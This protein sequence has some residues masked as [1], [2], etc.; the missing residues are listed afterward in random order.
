VAHTADVA[1]A[2]HAASGRVLRLVLCPVRCC[3]SIA[4]VLLWGQLVSD[5]VPEVAQVGEQSVRCAV[6]QHLQFAAC[7]TRSC[8][9]SVGLGH[10]V[11]AGKCLGVAYVGDVGQACHMEGMDA[12]I[13]QPGGAVL[14]GRGGG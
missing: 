9:H 13:K 6:L 10:G 4:A 14:L 5:G 7:R 3:S 1:A 2:A 12:C 8:R 11:H